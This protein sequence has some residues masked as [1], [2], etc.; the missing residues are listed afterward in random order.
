MA[1]N[2]PNMLLNSL[3]LFSRRPLV[4]VDKNE[5]IV[6]SNGE[7]EERDYF[8]D[9]QRCGDADICVEADGRCNRRE[10]YHHASEAER[11]LAVDEQRRKRL[12]LCKNNKLYI[13]NK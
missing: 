3:A 10:D 1:Q 4:S 7:N 8:D 13:K 6:R 2:T 5:D 12:S 11:Y 9:D